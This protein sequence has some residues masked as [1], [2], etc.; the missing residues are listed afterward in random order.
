MCWRILPGPSEA[1]EF[2]KGANFS[3]A[4]ARQ[5]SARYADESSTE[6][7]T[8]QP[9]TAL[10]EAALNL[11]W[12]PARCERAARHTLGPRPARTAQPLQ[13]ERRITSQK[14][15]GRDGGR[16]DR[17]DADLTCAEPAQEVP[18]RIGLVH[19]EALVGA[20]VFLGRA[21]VV[22]HCHG[23]VQ[24]AIECETCGEAVSHTKS[25]TSRANL[26]S[27]MET[28]AGSVSAYELDGPAGVKV[29]L[30]VIYL[31]D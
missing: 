17:I 3:E 20:P 27:G 22:E 9:A 31:Q 13:G 4:V 11:L 23:I 28:A 6:S 29:R 10:V 14:I 16:P 15:R 24:L 2:G 30:R 5:L 26:V 19:F 8:G 1:R 25:A 21:D 12:V 7:G 18:R